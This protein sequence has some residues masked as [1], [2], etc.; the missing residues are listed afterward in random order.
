MDNMVVVYA[1]VATRWNG[2]ACTQ[3]V[4]GLHRTRDGAKQ[5]LLERVH[6]EK[7]LFLGLGP[8]LTWN[9]EALE[10][11]LKNRGIRYGLDES[12]PT[13]PVWWMRRAGSEDEV[14]MSIYAMDLED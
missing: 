3:E 9:H 14:L 6:A 4:V 8:A 10:K 12:C 2:G 1:V 11:A 5:H 7:S 13:N